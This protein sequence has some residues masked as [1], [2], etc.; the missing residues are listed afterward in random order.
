[1][2][3]LAKLEVGCG[4]RHFPGPGAERRTTSSGERRSGSAC[5]RRPVAQCGGVGSGIDLELR[6]LGEHYPSCAGARPRAASR[7][8]SAL[9]G[10]KHGSAGARARRPRRSRRPSHVDD[11]SSAPSECSRQSAGVGWLRG[12]DPPARG[13]DALVSIATATISSRAAAARHAHLP[14]GQVHPAASP[15][16]PRAEED[17]RALE[18]AERYGLPSRS[19]RVMSEPPPSSGAATDTGPSAHNPC[20]SLATSAIPSASANRRTFTRPFVSA[21]AARQRDAN[22]A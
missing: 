11:A 15:A 18:R 17:L 6:C 3:V 9:A 14:H 21:R 10:A 4:K 12:I 19:G 22:F 2:E 5:H 13:L 7:H 16:R 20:D 1:M 8:Q